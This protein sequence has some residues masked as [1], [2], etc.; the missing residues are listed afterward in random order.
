MDDKD[1]IVLQ[2][3]LKV[4]EDNNKILKRG[5]RRHFYSS[6]WRF[7][8]WIFIIGLAYSSYYYLQPYLTKVVDMYNSASSQLEKVQNVTD[9]VTKYIPS[10][11]K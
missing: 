2:N 1:K 10:T 3:I 11:K 5:E 4:T 6:V 8:Y 9:S 7:L